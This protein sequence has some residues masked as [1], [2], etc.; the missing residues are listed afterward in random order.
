MTTVNQANFRTRERISLDV[1][2]GDTVIHSKYSGEEYLILSAGDVLAVVS[3]L[4]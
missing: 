3:Q 2:E 4:A 1:S